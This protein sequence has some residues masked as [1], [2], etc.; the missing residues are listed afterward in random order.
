[1]REVDFD[2]SKGP[3]EAPLRIELATEATLPELTHV[4]KAA[5]DALRQRGE[6]TWPPAF[7]EPSALRQAYP[8]SEMFLGSHGGEVVCSMILLD[9]DPDFWPDVP[10]GSSLFIH[11]LAVL[12]SA[13]GR[14]LATRLLDFAE[15]RANQQGKHYLRLDCH[16]QRPLIQHFYEAR[17]FVR[18]GYRRVGTFGAALYERAVPV[19]DL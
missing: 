15:A 1:M 3:L 18:V 4:L 6:P 10:A 16:A 2:S 11:K 7:L 14:G 8:A 9:D 5:A 19:G 13:Q 12:P 17:G